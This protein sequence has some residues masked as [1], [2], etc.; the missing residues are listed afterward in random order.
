MLPRL[1]S[2][3]LTGKL[4]WDV[5]I[6]GNPTP[7]RLPLSLPLVIHLCHHGLLCTANYFPS[8]CLPTAFPKQFALTA[9]TAFAVLNHSVIDF[10]TTYLQSCNSLL[11]SVSFNFQSIQNIQNF[12]FIYQHKHAPVF[13]LCCLQ[14]PALETLDVQT[15]TS[16]V[17]EFI[18]LLPYLSEGNGSFPSTSETIQNTPPT[19][20]TPL[21]LYLLPKK[22]REGRKKRQL[23]HSKHSSLKSSK[24]LANSQTDDP[25]LTCGTFHSTTGTASERIITKS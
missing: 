24:F 9:A 22:K 6:C 2:S 5:H 17:T 3:I 4:Q 25:S 10:Y 11:M 7:L 15:R 21:I 18:S 23:K 14:K 12:S 13:D 8:V 16:L 19:S 1:K 20:C